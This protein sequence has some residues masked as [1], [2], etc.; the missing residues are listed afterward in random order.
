[1][2]LIFSDTSNI[3]VVKNKDKKPSEKDRYIH[4]H[5]SNIFYGT[6]DL[7]CTEHE[8]EE[9]VKRAKKNKE[10]ISFLH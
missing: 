5:I 9:M 1:M 7:L 2:F 6:E 8:F 3:N 4:I 10:D